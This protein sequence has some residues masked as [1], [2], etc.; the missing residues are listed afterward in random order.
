MVLACGFFLDV[1]IVTS[2]TGS[3]S[4]NRETKKAADGLDEMS[5]G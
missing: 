3:N 1:R 5:E 2:H 4:P